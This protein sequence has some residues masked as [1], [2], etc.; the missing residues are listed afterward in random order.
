MLTTLDEKLFYKIH[1]ITVKYDKIGRW[2]AVITQLSSKMF[3]SLYIAFIVLMLLKMDEILIPFVIGPGASYLI[4]KMIRISFKRDR[5][6]VKLKIK[7]Y[8]QHEKD[9]SFPSMHAMSAFSIATAIY[10]ANPI[11]GCIAYIIAI[12]TGI[13]RIIVGVHFP[14]DV[15]CGGGI[16]ILV[17]YTVFR[18]IS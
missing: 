16:G 9:S 10:L 2:M 12:L 1:S 15:I 5:P 18:L 7:H 3:F 11:M 17:T 8:I 14:L 6:F 4:T 13:S